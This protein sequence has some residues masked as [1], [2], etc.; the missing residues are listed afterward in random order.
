MNQV[1][2]NYIYYIFVLKTYL[3]IY[4]PTDIIGL[5]IMATYQPV[6]IY[7]GYHY[8]ILTSD[9]NYM[10]KSSTIHC[11][12]YGS[13]SPMHPFRNECEKFISD[14]DI[15]LIDSGWDHII[16]SKKSSNEICILHQSVEYKYRSVRDKIISIS[17]GSNYSIVLTK[18]GRL[19]SWGAN[20]DGRLGLGHYDRCQE[21]FQEVVLYQNIIKISCGG[22]HVICLDTLGKCYVW[23]RNDFGQLGLGHNLHQNLPQELGLNLRDVMSVNCGGFHTVMLTFGYEVFVWGC[24]DEYQLGLENRRSEYLPQKLNLV[25]VVS[26]N[27]GR[28]HTIALTLNNKIYVWG[29]NMNGQ[30]GF[31]DGMFQSIPRLLMLDE[32]IKSIRCGAEY[33]FAISSV[34]KIYLLGNKKIEILNI[35]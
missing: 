12:V 9:K 16:V 24:N 8:A 31:N 17:S 15:E 29:F 14:T 1:R 32:P 11:D 34:D 3:G 20:E 26:I 25:D 22:F 21:S 2:G 33:T 35:F 19:Y 10:W 7:C 18:N 23:G 30:L 5:I 4:Y 13:D 28:C 27:C 6:K